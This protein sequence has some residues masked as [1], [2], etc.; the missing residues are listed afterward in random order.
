MNRTPR[1][2]APAIA[3]HWTIAVLI[4]GLIP[5]GLYMTGLQLSILKIRLFAW[6]KW[7]GLTVL[8]L[9]VARL[10][11]RAGH[12]PPPL[13]GAIPAWQRAIAAGLHHLL[14]VL[15][16]VIPLT[17]WATSSAAGVQVVWWGV[18][19]LPNL[20]AKNDALAHVLG[21]VHSLLNDALIG[22]VALHVAAALKHHIIDRDGVLTR[23]LPFLH[24][25]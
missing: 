22:L 7:L 13:P 17:G 3:L 6:H 2:T 1:Y 10:A 23:M 12:A 19:P 11:W 25:E 21:T 9:A 18:L 24:Q 20:L 8:A 5:L 15:M 14:Y 4:L 16:F